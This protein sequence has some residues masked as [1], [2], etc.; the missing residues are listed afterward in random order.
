MLP[1]DTGSTPSAYMWL[2]TIS[3]VG[4]GSTPASDL[5]TAGLPMMHRYACSENTHTNK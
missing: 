4:G 5:W 2:A 3:E 1:E